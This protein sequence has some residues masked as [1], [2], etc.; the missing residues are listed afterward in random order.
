MERRQEVWLQASSCGSFQAQSAWQPRSSDRLGEAF[1]RYEI[2]LS[3]RHLCFAL[4]HSFQ[5]NPAHQ[6]QRIS[7]RRTS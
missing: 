5:H 2:V 1:G 4:D 7:Q 3:R 6:H